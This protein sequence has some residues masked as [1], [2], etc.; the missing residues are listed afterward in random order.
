MEGNNI[1]LTSN[2]TF[3]TKISSECPVQQQHQQQQESCE[4]SNNKATHSTSYNAADDDDDDDDE[5]VEQSKNAFGTSTQRPTDLLTPIYIGQINGQTGETNQSSSTKIRSTNQSEMRISEEKFI[6]LRD[7]ISV[8]HIYR[9]QSSC[10]GISIVGGIDTPLTS[11]VVQEVHKNGAAYR[12]GRL[13][14][15]DHILQAFGC[16]LMKILFSYRP[17]QRRQ[18]NFEMSTVHLA[19]SF[20]AP[21][22]RDVVEPNRKA[23]V[24]KLWKE[25]SEQYHKLQKAEFKIIAFV[26]K[27]NM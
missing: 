22:K 26:P 10:L 14:P 5:K 16:A 11:V 17:L 13:A 25:L 3:V 7:R 8:L 18:D 20:Q 21:A 2:A 12:D 23:P 24:S 4:A 15:G 19:D 27:R 6:D 1:P 9:G